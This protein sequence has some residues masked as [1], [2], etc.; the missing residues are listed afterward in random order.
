MSQKESLTRNQPDSTLNL[1]VQPLGCVRRCASAVC[2]YGGLNGPLH[3]PGRSA[4][5]R[6]GGSL[7][8]WCVADPSGGGKALL[9]AD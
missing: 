6:R 1:G 7:V 2:G 8:L 4:P 5:R 3:L 9:S